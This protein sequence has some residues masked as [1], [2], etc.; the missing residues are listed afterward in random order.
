MMDTNSI[1]SLRPLPPS[2]APPEM[3]RAARVAPETARENATTGETEYSAPLAQAQWSGLVGVQSFDELLRRS[4]PS[5]LLTRVGLHRKYLPDV[6]L[7]ENLQR[8]IGRAW[9][10]R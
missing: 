9:V 7:P 10:S 3:K 8:A 5:E 2:A 4:T 1:V 6:A